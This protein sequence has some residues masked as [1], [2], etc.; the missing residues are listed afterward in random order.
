MKK[1]FYFLLEGIRTRVL[2]IKRTIRWYP[3]K[4]YLS[5]FQHIFWLRKVST[6]LSTW[7]HVGMKFLFGPLHMTKGSKTTLSNKL[8]MNHIYPFMNICQQAIYI[9]SKAATPANP[10][11]KVFLTM[12]HQWSI[13]FEL[14]FLF[15]I[16]LS[17][18]WNSN[19][20]LMIT[21]GI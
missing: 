13:F 9:S 6:H 1:D 7:L 17:Y 21:V 8:F 11:D 16:L 4:G 18:L 5:T 3:Q 14:L 20:I 12:L 2:L 19:R 10:K 15:G